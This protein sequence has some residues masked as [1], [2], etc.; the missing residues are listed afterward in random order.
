MQ[1]QQAGVSVNTELVSRLKIG[2]RWYG[3]GSV[4]AVDQ[5]DF[6]ILELRGFA[7]RAPPGSKP[8][9]VE[10]A[11]VMSEPETVALAD[12]PE[13]ISKEV[14]SH[15]SPVPIQHSRKRR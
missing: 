14:S 4:V 10:Q 5:S 3:P 2:G 15:G 7:R 12:I 8:L 9:N 11:P 6:E 1:V 13:V